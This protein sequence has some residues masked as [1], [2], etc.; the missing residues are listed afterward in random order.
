MES[1][2]FAAN[3]ANYRLKTRTTNTV[4]N[5]QALWTDDTCYKTTQLNRPPAL[6]DTDTHCIWQWSILNSCVISGIVLSFAAAKCKKS[7]KMR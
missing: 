3:N 4:L 1:V 2:H 7:G 6:A 5:E